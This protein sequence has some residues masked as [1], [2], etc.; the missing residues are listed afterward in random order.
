MGSEHS[1]NSYNSSEMHS[2]NKDKLKNTIKLITYNIKTN[3]Y[4]ENKFQ[5]ILMY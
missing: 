3:S 5:N 4:S 2:E 1:K